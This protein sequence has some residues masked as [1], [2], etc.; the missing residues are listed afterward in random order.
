MC[1][2]SPVRAPKLQLAV[3]QPST[4]G[5]WN[6]PTKD[7]SC[8]KTKKK[9][10]QDGRRGTITIKSNPIPAGWMTHKL[11][12]DN[13]KEVLPLLWRF[14]I[15]HQA[16]QP[17]NRAKELEIPK[18]SDLEGQWDLITELSQDW[19][20]QRLHTWRAHLKSSTYQNPG[21]RSSDPT[22]DWTRATC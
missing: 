17:R 18:E 16:S 14:W 2:S 9:L 22:R 10:Q 19:G 21:E 5:H 13:N 7:T 11:E 8:P 4:G 6:Q 15:P 1:S 20:K 3:E 12:N